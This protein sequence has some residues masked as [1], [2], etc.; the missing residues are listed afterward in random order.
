[1]GG[2]LGPAVPRVRH[3]ADA[4][5]RHLGR[6]FADADADD[7]RP[8]H[9]A[10]LPPRRGARCGGGS[11]APSSARFTATQRGYARTPR[12]GRCG[13]R[14]LMLLVT[15]AT[16]GLTVWLYTVVP[17]GFLPTQDT[18]L[19][20]GSTLADP[21][22]SFA[23]M[24]ERQRAVVDVHPGRSGGR[25]GRFRHRRHLRLVVAEPRTADHQ[26]EAAGRA[27][28]VLR[29]GDRPAAARRWRGSAGCRPSFGP[30]RICAAA[31]AAAVP[32]SSC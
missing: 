13:F 23:A 1:M 3:D 32:T 29:A 17:K 8:L 11:T 4:R 21:S 20:Q 26:P 12:A 31:A 24:G 9:D 2:I 25:G 7:V 10:W 15:F 19:L 27:R 22:I 18:G 14:W 5:H 6:G 16:I 30:P 28:R